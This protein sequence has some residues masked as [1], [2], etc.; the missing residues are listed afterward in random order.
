MLGPKPIR[1]GARV[2]VHCPTRSRNPTRTAVMAGPP[3]FIGPYH[4]F[5]ALGRG[6]MGV[7]YRAQHRESGQSVALKTIDVPNEWALSG[8]RREI[9]ALARI[10]HPQVVRVLDEGVHGGLPWYAMEL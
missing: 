5:E 10:R 7:V 2:Q 4:L 6:G 3:E 9:Q 1:S 8:L